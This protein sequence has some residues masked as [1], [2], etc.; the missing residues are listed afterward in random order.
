[1]PLQMIL[2]HLAL[3]CSEDDYDFVDMPDLNT[4][5]IHVYISQDGFVKYF[6]FNLRAISDTL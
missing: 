4:S 5:Y 3:F 6:D 1:M 2:L